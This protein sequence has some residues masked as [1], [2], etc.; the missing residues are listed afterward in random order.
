MF[1]LIFLT[2][3]LNCYWLRPYLFLY[4]SLLCHVLFAQTCLNLKTHRCLYHQQMI[5]YEQYCK[6]LVYPECVMVTGLTSC[7]RVSG[8]CF[9]GL[10]IY[11]LTL[12]WNHYL[13]QEVM[14][15]PV[16]VC[17]QDISKCI[18]PIVMKVCGRVGHRPRTN[19]LNF[20]WICIVE[21]WLKMS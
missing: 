16:F 17:R 15:S 6:K 2:L 13:C 11:V 5:M 14:V 7:R 21:N 10:W 9:K 8:L 20:C 4:F 12:K 19:P 3:M 1:F 18:A